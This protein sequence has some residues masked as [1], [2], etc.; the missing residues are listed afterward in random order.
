M[1]LAR[2]YDPA[3]GR[4]VTTLHDGYLDRLSR[5]SDIQDYLETL[6]DCACSYEK[7]PA[8]KTGGHV[9]S[10]DIAYAPGDPEGMRPW[11]PNRYW[12]FI[13]GDDMDPA[14]REQFPGQADVLFI[15]TSHEYEH[16][17][18][19][20]HAFMPRVAPGGTAFFHDTKLHDWPGY[21]PPGD[22]PPVAQALDEY[23]GTTGLSWEDLPGWYGM[24][25]IRL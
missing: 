21:E 11:C 3:K 2:V 24:G 23:C 6:Y 22:K 5:K 12:T 18:G 17:L 25:M 13:H 19:E 15:D 4:V 20:L 10:N 8:E 9:W 14:V 7:V 16:T 1:P